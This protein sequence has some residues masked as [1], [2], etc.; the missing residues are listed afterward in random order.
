MHLRSILAI[1]RKDAFDIIVNKSTFFS[2]L[3]II[4]VAVLF[5]LIRKKQLD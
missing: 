4:F 5:L 3:S 2:L 1:A